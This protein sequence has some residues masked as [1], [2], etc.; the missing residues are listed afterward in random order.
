MS[1]EAKSVPESAACLDSTSSRDPGSFDWLSLSSGKT[2]RSV[3]VAL[4]PT[5]AILEGFSVE[6]MVEPLSNLSKAVCL[7]TSD[8]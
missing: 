5:N 8:I 7:R 6:E 3:T 2:E 4:E 1:C